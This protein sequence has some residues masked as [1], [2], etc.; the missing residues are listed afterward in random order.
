MGLDSNGVR[1][2]L[3]ARSMGVRFE[4]T[5]MIGRQELFLSRKALA[6]ALESYG[7]GAG[8][9][10]ASILSENKGYA[11]P[12]LRALGATEVHSYDNSTYEGA[13]HVH[14]MNAPIPADCKG[15]Y[16]L[17]IDG[18]TLEHVFNVAVAF[19]NVM[20][21]VAPG[22]HLIVI[23]PTNNF[24]GHGFYQFSPE[25][26]FRVFSEANGYRVEQFIVCE[27]RVDAPWYSV[28]DPDR[29]R[30]RIGF[31]NKSPTNAL[32]I[33]R[34]THEVEPFARA[35]QQ[36]DYTAAWQ[37]AAPPAYRETLRARV[38]RHAP[39]WFVHI[40]SKYLRGTLERRKYSLSPRNGFHRLSRSG[41]GRE[42]S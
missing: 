11:E 6:G 12:F 27:D 14:D 18:G 1:L 31:I 36:S 2:L 3:H 23:A 24:M 5:A 40:A 19:R 4:R 33:A 21:M 32:V 30:R 42:R 39:D 25:F 9:D 22:G 34:R 17:V 13:T 35:P 15:R 26:Y 38:K 10:A 8:A 37:G 7:L 16:S 29:L 41:D 20:E 28:D